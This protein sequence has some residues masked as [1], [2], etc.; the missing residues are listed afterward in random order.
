MFELREYQQR[1][2]SATIEHCKKS[3]EPAF[4]AASVGA[5]KTLLI[6][7]MAKHVTDKGGRVLVLARQGELIEQNANDAW[8]IGCKT[9]I[10]SA[11]LN[12]KST[13]FPCIMGTEGTVANAIDD[14]FKCTKFDLLMID[15]CLT[16]DS[17]ITTDKG[18]V[19]IADID[20]LNHKVACVDE[21][22]GRVF[23]ENPLRV[24]SNGVK[25]ISQVNTKEGVTL[26]CTGN[27]KIFANDSWTQAQYLQDSDKILLIDTQST[28]L[29]RVV[30]ASAAV[31][32]RLLL[33]LTD[34][35][36]RL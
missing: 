30:R 9:S 11:S 19:R 33:E 7:F 26:K 20:I 31:A 5:G 10:Y 28:I 3:S 18:L 23:Y 4:V 6:G 36:L 27:H 29:T 2:H 22:S 32:K 34:R 15:E 12:S 14:E 13:T 16:G 21:K 17:L 35:I 25:S 1:A 24:W 8:V